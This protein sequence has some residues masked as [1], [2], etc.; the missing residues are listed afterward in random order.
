M[1]SLTS[2]DCYAVAVLIDL[3][4]DVAPPPDAND[5]V[6]EAD[7]STPLF[8]EDDKFANPSDVLYQLPGLLDVQNKL[9]TEKGE[10]LPY[11]VDK[12]HRVVAL[13]HFTLLEYLTSKENQRAGSVTFRAG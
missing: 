11:P 6:S 7:Y 5:Q 10:E 12:S 8:S 9:F 13:T 2:L 3:V 1:L 4:M